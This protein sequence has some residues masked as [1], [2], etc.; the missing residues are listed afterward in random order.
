MAKSSRSSTKKS[1]KSKLRKKVFSPAEDAR[2]ER[3]SNK[4][5]ELASR[6][7]PRS[8]EDSVMIEDKQG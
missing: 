4:L 5:L 7:H 2:T 6:S 1:N 3:L 8:P